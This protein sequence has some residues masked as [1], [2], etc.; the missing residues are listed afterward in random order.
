MS[1]PSDTDMMFCDTPI[2]RVGYKTL[3]GFIRMI[4]AQN[5]K[6][7]KFGVKVRFTIDLPIKD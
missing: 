7:K 2:K 3:R 1:W 6:V 5:K 4:K